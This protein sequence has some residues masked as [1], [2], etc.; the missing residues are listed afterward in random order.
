MVEHVQW[1]IPEQHERI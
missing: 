1:M